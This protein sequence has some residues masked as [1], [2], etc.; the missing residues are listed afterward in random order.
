[1]KHSDFKIG[2]AFKCNGR[3]YQVTDVGTRIVAAIRFKRGW[4][5]GPPYDG[6]ELVFDEDDFPVCEPTRAE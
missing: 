6:A 3:R 2:T 5:D 4:M 1:M